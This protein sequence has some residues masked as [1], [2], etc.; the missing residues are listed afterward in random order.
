M[1]STSLV[2]VYDTTKEVRNSKHTNVEKLMRRHPRVFNLTFPSN[3][4]LFTDN[5]VHFLG[6]QLPILLKVTWCGYGPCSAEP[7]WGAIWVW[8]TTWP[9]WGF[10]LE[11]IQ[12]NFSCERWGD[13]HVE[14]VNGVISPQDHNNTAGPAS[15]SD[16]VDNTPPPTSSYNI[17]IL[18]W[19]RQWDL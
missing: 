9:Q 10:I 8:L 1:P 18:E 2:P 14:H 11:I 19:W 13:T 15:C 6:S 7:I 4:V 12:S 16:G 3:S 17:S 5:E